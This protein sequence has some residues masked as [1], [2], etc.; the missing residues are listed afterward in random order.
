VSRKKER[1]KVQKDHGATALCAPT[2]NALPSL[3]VWFWLLFYDA[4]SHHACVFL[5]ARLHLEAGLPTQEEMLQRHANAMRN[6]NARGD[7]NTRRD[8]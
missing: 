2:D 7:G 8:C 6:G 3:L 5:F 4:L 1:Q